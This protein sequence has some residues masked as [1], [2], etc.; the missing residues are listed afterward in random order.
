MSEGATGSS[1][2]GALPIFGTF[3]AVRELHRG[4]FGSVFAAVAADA[5]ASAPA[6][7]VIKTCTPPVEV[8]G[9]DAAQRIVRA[10]IDSYSLQ[11]QLTGGGG[12]GV[13]GTTSTTASAAAASAEIGGTWGNGS[14]RW[15]RVHALDSCAGRSTF[16]STSGDDATIA[17]P[18]P[19]AYVVLDRG[20]GVAGLTLTNAD[21]TLQSLI[22]THAE[23]D[24]AFVRR[25]FSEV[26]Q[27]LLR[28]RSVAKRGHGDLR[29][30][31]ILLV[32]DLDTSARPL[33]AKPA[34]DVPLLSLD[35]LHVALTDPA[36][37]WNVGDTERDIR[38]LA[39]AVHLLV[40]FK[41]YQDGWSGAQERWSALGTG[42]GAI[43]K[44]IESILD[45]QA[46]VGDG[47]V[48]GL[49]VEDLASAMAKTAKAADRKKAVLAGV[50]LT[51][52]LCGSVGGYFYWRHVQAVAAGQVIKRWNENP[53]AA[54]D[55]W[56][57]FCEEYRQWFAFLLKR[58]DEKPS[59]GVLTAVQ[60]SA[61]GGAGASTSSAAPR[62]DS[63]RDLFSLDTELAVI[64]KRLR[65]ER[66]YAP[67]SAD[68]RATDKRTS[69]WAIA[70]VNEGMD[71]QAMALAPTDKARE[72]ASMDAT[73]A[74]LAVMRDVRERLTTWK[75]PADLKAAGDE[76]NALGWT[77]AGR[78]LQTLVGRFSGDQDNLSADVAGDI[79]AVVAVRP[80]VES[81]RARWKEIQKTLPEITRIEDPVL[82]RFTAAP[83]SFIT[84]MDGDAGRAGDL[85]VLDDQ[86]LALR[87]QS[88]ALAEFLKTRWRS[89]D[90][91]ALR[92]GPEYRALAAQGAGAAAASSQLL[93]QWIAAAEKYPALD[94]ATDPRRG[95]GVEEAITAIDALIPEFAGE[96]LDQPLDDATLSTINKLK[97]DAQAASPDKLGWTRRNQQR[98]EAEAT[99][100]K[101]AAASLRAS[102]EKRKTDRLAEQAAT[103]QRVRTELGS[104]ASVVE[105]SP[106]LNAQWV[107]GRDALLASIETKRYKELTRRAQTLENAVKA[108]DGA[109]PPALRRDDLL[110]GSNSGAEWAEAFVQATIARRDRL[111]S[112]LLGEGDATSERFAGLLPA[113]EKAGSEFGTFMQGLKDLVA[114]ARELGSALAAGYA[115]DESAGTRGSIQ[116][117]A[118]AVSS[119]PGM[120]EPA[121]A[122]ALAPL[123]ARVDAFKAVASEADAGKLVAMIQA[124]G[125]GDVKRPE[126]VLS[127]WRRL[128]DSGV[129]FPV[130]IEDLDTLVSL[131]T[132][133]QRTVGA[134]S[135][136]ARRETL[137][138]ALIDREVPRR[139]IAF[140]SSRTTAADMQAALAKREALSV[141]IDELPAALAYNQA[142]IDARKKLETGGLDEM[143][144]YEEGV[145]FS[146]SVQSGSVASTG[147][148]GGADIAS[149]PG[150]SAMLARIADLT[151]ERPDQVKK[152]DPKTLG[153]GSIGWRAEEDEQT[154]RLTFT[155]PSNVTIIFE[156]VEPNPTLGTDA[157]YI[158]QTE[159]SLR[160][161]LGL[162]STPEQRNE[163]QAAM[164]IFEEDTGWTG[165]R[166]W[167]WKPDRA[168]TKFDIAKGT[169]WL[170]KDANIT[171]QDPAFAADILAPGTD[172]S[173]RPE[174]GGDPSL[175][176]PMQC[177][178]PTAA[179]YVCRLA[180]CRFPT[181][182]EWKAA[183][184]ALMVSRNQ[185]GNNWNIRDRIF[186]VQRE[187]ILA[188][189]NRVQRKASFQFPDSGIAKVDANA[190]AGARAAARKDIDDGVLYFAK[191]DADQATLKHL[192]GNVAEYAFDDAAAFELAPPTVKGLGQVVEKKNAP[193]RVI[194]ASALSPPSVSPETPSAVDVLAAGE[195]FADVGFRMLFGASGT[196]IKA[197][198]LAVKLRKALADDAFILAQ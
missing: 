85:R 105:G 101:D 152:I 36:V 166:V 165:P 17:T 74:M 12:G 15:A 89:I 139:Y 61:G 31:N 4:P 64:V 29:P 43:R 197:E 182:A 185:S 169:Q 127:A 170:F 104:K 8:V 126:L 121:V 109:L 183:Y 111:I 75:G 23:V 195:G 67:G 193:L 122:Q 142:L 87:D 39:H 160:V 161:V 137:S 71:L 148:N 118:G 46:S 94:P 50:G 42:G 22:R 76:L 168:G 129:K 192:V 196:A 1:T 100:L 187:H 144:A 99:R 68:A 63:R 21:G 51:L 56:R 177:L 175:D 32:P 44:L 41:P 92:E 132:I 20:H 123:V 143:G 198:P 158:A 79:D 73:E 65:D 95:W 164:P 130:K 5:Q 188:M 60:Q 81:I 54:Q 114:I 28:A 172:N 106:V 162:L 133:V 9:L 108:L 3:R 174:R 190:P 136:G 72:D 90:A 150:V 194:G 96:D 146:Q 186:D 145:R 179:A 7:Y 88:R 19:G 57:E 163:F 131:R 34:E 16:D 77:R 135:D 125:A 184:D 153:P 191:V 18:S 78:Y 181:S 167:E 151:R 45:P 58:L 83:A 86:L 80:R 176:H 116:Q 124:E 110:A 40:T 173:I 35:R 154:G 117:M 33:D 13:G 120:Q 91:E 149:R 53:Q 93:Q 102:I 52:A 84:G 48:A 69:P 66:V 82:A 70:E 138:E 107:R 97:A 49:G 98:V 24:A 156:R 157:F 10:F 62:I 2:S 47:R 140:A 171:P 26:A 103:A 37:T 178:G 119:H 180:G 189:Q 141:K 55:N 115:P 147:G 134:I 112:S 30:S 155:S 59:A 128:G 113:A 14:P 159:A 27:G 38:A 11:R 6:A 25:L